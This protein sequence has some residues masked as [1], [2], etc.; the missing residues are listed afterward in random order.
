[1]FGRI[2]EESSVKEI[3]FFLE[4]REKKILKQQVGMSFN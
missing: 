4:N 3:F 2:F 1:M